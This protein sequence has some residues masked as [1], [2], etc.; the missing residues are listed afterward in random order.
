VL[1]ALPKGTDR[2]GSL[3][4]EALKMIYELY[5]VEAKLKEK[6]GDN[7][8]EAAIEAI[9]T[10]RQQTSAGICDRRWNTA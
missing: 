4:A 1:D 8:A 5:A 2:S 10:E 7:L 6:W 3:A 9:L